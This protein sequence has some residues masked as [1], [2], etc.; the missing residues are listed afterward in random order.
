MV[1][2]QSKFEADL[3][4]AVEAQ[5]NSADDR[6]REDW[7]GAL[8]YV[9]NHYR[10]PMSVQAVRLRSAWSISSSIH[11]LVR[12]LARQVGLQATFIDVDN[13]N[14][15]AWQLPVI[16]EL[17]DGAIGVVTSLS[18]E[19][20]AGVVFPSDGGRANVV[21]FNLLMRE[22]RT[23]LVARPEQAVPDER[24][25]SYIKPY[26]Q[27]WIRKIVLRDL[28]P[29]RHVMMASLVAN[30]LG[31][32]GIIFSMQTY[33]RVVPAQSYPTLYVLFIGVM[34]A[35]AI[36]FMMRYTR[37]TVVDLL[38]RE[39]DLRMTDKIMGHALRVKNRVRPQ[40]T[41]TFIAQ[42]RDLDQVREMLTSS[43]VTAL[44]DIPFFLLFLTVYGSLVGSLV[45]IP[46]VA[47]IVMVTPSL[48]SQKKLEA[49]SK[50][51][52]RE[53]SLRN[54]M[55]VEAVQGLEDIKVLQAEERFQQQ[56]NHVN[57]VTSAANIKLRKLTSTLSLWTSTTQAAVFAITIFI[58][59]PMVMTGDMTT[60]ALIGASILGSRM[61]QPMASA[62]Q[63]LS[64][65]QQ[66]KMAAKSLD[67]LMRMPIDHPKKE[68]RIHVSNFSGK[69]DFKSVIYRYGTADGPTALE[70]DKLSI[71]P[72]DK[73]AILG[74]NGAGKSTLLQAMS[75]L[76]EPSEGEVTFDDFALAHLDPADLRRDIVL[77][78]QNSQLFF[79][80]IRDNIMM[81]APH[82]TSAQ[83]D[84]ALRM[85][86]A[87]EFIRK[88][89]KGLDYVVREGGHGL[90]GGQKQAILL[91][92]LLVKD[93]R[94][95]LLD[96]P[97]ASMDEGTERNFISQLQTW[98]ADKTIIIATHRM[99][100]LDLVDRIIVVENGKIVLDDRKDK[101]LLKLR[102]LSKSKPGVGTA[103]SEAPKKSE[104]EE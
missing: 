38:G 101:A 29:Y 102:S 79:G 63:L 73:I 45:V 93:P 82:A 37:T 10:L 64:R 100:V 7:I 19:G 4:K 61:M 72:G 21:P 77:L 78:T 68:N 62:T 80:R 18:A 56:W 31:L 40:S 87:D 2:E 11:D 84:A 51:A 42:I 47:L 8:R 28:K 1:Q 98:G 22:T 76:L 39:A 48:L 85:V 34:I 13:A 92:R 17:M 14:I 74:K 96:E 25:D 60:G 94:I 23:L 35:I 103:P 88:L 90:S 41:G 75:G 97:T 52:M 104:A 50:Q 95:L 99:R 89:P 3:Q 24:V 66:A 67:E 54:A 57:S 46:I 9:A 86:G 49:Y 33:D 6:S 43:T 83:V 30:V 69:M 20:E 55:L 12:E 27:H 81:G 44:A 58:G 70:I 36:D 53:S 65:W 32:A 5:A 26:E 59:A 71:S 91:A 15:S 16:V